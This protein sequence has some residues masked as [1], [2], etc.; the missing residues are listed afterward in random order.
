MDFE[1]YFEAQLEQIE[2]SYFEQTLE[3]R[4]E[5]E[6][7]DPYSDYDDDGDYYGAERDEIAW[8]MESLGWEVWGE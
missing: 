7:Y 8:Q 3:G 5:L 2:D 4:F 1:Q 6:E